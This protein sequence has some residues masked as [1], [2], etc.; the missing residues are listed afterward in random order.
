MAPLDDVGTTSF[1]RMSRRLADDL[2]SSVSM[3]DSLPTLRETGPTTKTRLLVDGLL[4]RFLKDDIFKILTDDS[5]PTLLE[6]GL[7]TRARLLVDDLPVHLCKV[8]SVLIL[9]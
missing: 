5:L 4:L 3:D 9:I 1:L 6:A 7:T 2:Q 8:V